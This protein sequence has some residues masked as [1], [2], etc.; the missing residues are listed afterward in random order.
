MWWFWIVNLF[1]F[2]ITY[3]L[4]R[5]AA[6]IQEKDSV[7]DIIWVDDITYGDIFKQ[8]EIDFFNL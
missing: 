1:Q 2:E 7:Y 4:E 8:N 6:Y 3:G 5:L